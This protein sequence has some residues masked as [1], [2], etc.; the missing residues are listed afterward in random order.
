MAMKLYVEMVKKLPAHYKYLAI[1]EKIT[2]V[3]ADLGLFAS[4]GIGRVGIL[5]I[6]ESGEQLPIVELAVKPE[7][8]RLEPSELTKVERFLNRAKPDMY[9]RV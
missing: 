7:R 5:L 1:P 8:F 9:V 6:R 4:D 3:A 2:N